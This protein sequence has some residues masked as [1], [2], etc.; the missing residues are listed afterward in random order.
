MKTKAA[1]LTNKKQLTKVKM[2][3]LMQLA[4][5]WFSPTNLKGVK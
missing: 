5:F 2:K 1:L 4:K 3:L